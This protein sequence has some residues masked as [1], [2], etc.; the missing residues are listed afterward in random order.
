[1]LKA[2]AGPSSYMPSPLRF[3]AG[4]DKSTRRDAPAV[5]PLFK[6]GRLYL[7]M[8]VPPRPRSLSWTMNI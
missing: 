7:E 8:A 2:G 1:M 4:A 6:R 3:D 5:E